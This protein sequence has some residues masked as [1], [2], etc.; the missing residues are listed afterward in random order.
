MI[1]CYLGGFNLIKASEI[2]LGSVIQVFITL[3][4]IYVSSRVTMHIENIKWKHEEK[5]QLE[6]ERNQ[7]L[8]NLI[9][10]GYRLVE[11]STPADR[12]RFPGELERV[13]S[14]FNHNQR[15][16]SIL[17]DIKK[18]YIPQGLFSGPA[19]EDGA[20]RE[21]LNDLNNELNI[22]RANNPK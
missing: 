8:E 3:L 9:N 2:F 7:A 4:T 14:Y 18:R 5:K 15:I 13:K 20:Y 12:N 17:D 11:V 1:E 22:I 19:C 10:L 6:Q 16:I 21:L